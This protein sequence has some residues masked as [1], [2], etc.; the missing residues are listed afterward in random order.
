MLQGLR[1][2]EGTMHPG[3]HQDTGLVRLARRNG[4]AAEES[5]KATREEAGPAWSE[6]VTTLFCLPWRSFSTARGPCGPAGVPATTPFCVLAGIARG[7]RLAEASAGQLAS[8]CARMV[9]RLR[10]APILYIGDPFLARL[11]RRARLWRPPVARNYESA[12][13]RGRYRMLVPFVT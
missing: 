7:R 13:A 4:C 10:M 6:S 5:T 11:Q 3:C 1:I 2:C 8:K 12:R 9:R